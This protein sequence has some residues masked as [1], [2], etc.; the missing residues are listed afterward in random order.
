MFTPL[1]TALESMDTFD[2]LEQAYRSRALSENRALLDQ[3]EKIF[4]GLCNRFP[5]NETFQ[6]QSEAIGLARQK[7]EAI[8]HAE[9]QSRAAVEA[10]L[11]EVAD[12]FHQAGAG[13]VDLKEWGF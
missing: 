7:L 12:L 10:G 13:Y 9:D 6:R 3:M 8:T 2:Q 5:L 1:E 4:S 11:A